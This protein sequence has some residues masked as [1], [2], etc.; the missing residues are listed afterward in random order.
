[1]DIAIIIVVSVS[2]TV[3]AD[4]V[5]SGRLRRA[6][7]ARRRLAAI[8]KA[9]ESRRISAAADTRRAHLENELASWN[10]ALMRQIGRDYHAAQVYRSRRDDVL[11]ELACL[12]P[13]SSKKTYARA[14]ETGS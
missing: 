12:P 9:R 11:A 6:I 8:A 13:S 7:M 5:M 10:S 4:L 3:L 1:M 14:E 2:V